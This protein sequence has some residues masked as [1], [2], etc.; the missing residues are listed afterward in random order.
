MRVDLS[1]RKG[2]K[3]RKAQKA[4]ITE[5]RCQFCRQASLVVDWQS[6]GDKCPRCERQFDKWTYLPLTLGDDFNA[7]RRIVKR[8][9][10]ELDEKGFPYPKQLQAAMRYVATRA[11]R[12]HRTGRGRHGAPTQPELA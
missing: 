5:Y 7:I 10:A 11:K 1:K 2:P 9:K 3:A 6:M 4:L 12:K 8:V